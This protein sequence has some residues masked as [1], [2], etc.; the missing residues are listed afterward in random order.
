MF[1]LTMY[2]SSVKKGDDYIRF[3]THPSKKSVWVM[4]DVYIS[5][6]K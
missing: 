3:V 4:P 1:V 6:C 2:S 5:N